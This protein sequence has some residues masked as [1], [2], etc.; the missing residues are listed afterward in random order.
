MM[1]IP[2]IFNPNLNG[3]EPNPD[4]LPSPNETV[5]FNYTVDGIL[6][7]GS[8]ATVFRAVHDGAE[9]RPVALKC[10][11]NDK[12]KVD[13]GL[14]EARIQA[15]IRL[16]D[17]HG[18]RHIVRLLDC[19]YYR[20]HLFLVYECLN[21]S[22]LAHY[23]HLETLGPRAR[24]EYWH[25]GSIGALS[26]QMLDALAFL[27]SL[28]ITHCDVKTANIC[29]VNA[30][31]R[32]FKLIDFGSVVLTYD[33]HM[34]Y[35]QSRWYR[36]PEVIL[37]LS[38]TP[39]IDVWSLGCVAI[40]LAFGFLPF[41]FASTDLVLAAHKATRGPFP[42]WMMEGPLGSIYFSSS[43][44]VYEVDPPAI[45]PGTYLLR[46]EPNT[47][48]HELLAQHLDPSIFGDVLSFSLFAET[49]LTLDPNVRPTAAE[50]LQHPWMASYGLPLDDPPIIPVTPSSSDVV[51]LKEK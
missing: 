34:S 29:I 37:G 32:I 5:G 24:A 35:L 45:A 31:R 4:F 26:I 42:P 2:T 7:S 30:E 44:C 51:S 12:E 49:L 48:L 15:L 9:N 43:G 16:H 36:A 46:S 3:M 8:F 33:A 18:R 11:K 19:F 23:M 50:A 22:V 13:A 14:G 20:E 28:G 25:A 10:L 40:E 41:Q 27:A 39:K 6:G 17:P 21:A 1:S 47:T 38:W